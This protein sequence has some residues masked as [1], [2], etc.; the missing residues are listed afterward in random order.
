[1]T[2]RGDPYRVLGLAQGASIAEVKRAYRLLAKRNHPDAGEGSLTRFLEIQAAY[3]VLARNGATGG[4]RSGPSRTTV[5]RPAQQGP[6][7]GGPRRANGE[8]AEDP[9][10]PPP[11]TEWAR[12]PRDGGGRPA[13]GGGGRP[14]TGAGPAGPT[15]GAGSAARD[16]GAGPTG[17]RGRRG[18][19]RRTA[20]LG[21]TTYDEAGPYDDAGRAADPAWDGADWY[22]PVSGTYWTVNPKEYADPRKH[23]PE[24][25]ARWSAAR[26][27]DS[28][29]RPPFDREPAQA[30]G[31]APPSPQ[32]PAAAVPPAVGDPGV[33]RADRPR[34]LVRL[35]HLVVA[36][37]GRLAGR[38]QRAG[39]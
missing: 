9:G 23:G 28:R 17:E 34:R 16:P 6:R 10:M 26:V 12:R 19:H 8:R 32:G 38:S 20:T 4:A 39:P 35:V 27:R 37:V 5:R 15:A 13:T 21:S 14:A 29:G 11:G 24:Y 31:A 25:L 3:E 33:G 7:G 18:R 2:F 22:G 36:A 30:A 1:M